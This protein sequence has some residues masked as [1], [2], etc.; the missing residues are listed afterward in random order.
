RHYNEGIGIFKKK[1]FSNEEVFDVDPFVQVRIFMLLMRKQDVTAHTFPA[2]F[3]CAP[4]CSFHNARATPRHDGEAQ[5]CHL[6]CNF[7]RII[8]IRM[9]FLKTCGSE[10]SYARAYEMKFSQ[11]PHNVAQYMKSKFEIAPPALR[12]S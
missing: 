11:T 5:L 9:I 1:S 7:S 4:V 12:T 8:V 3:A 6:S 10:N 2:H